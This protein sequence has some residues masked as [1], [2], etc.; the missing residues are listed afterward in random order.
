MPIF[1]V[2][3][4]D[5]ASGCSKCLF[6][7]SKDAK[8]AELNANKRGLFVSKTI[9]LD[10]SRTKMSDSYLSHAAR[11]L[12]DAGE[13]AMALRALEEKSLIPNKGTL[14]DCRFI[15][16][17]LVAAG[18]TDVAWRLLQEAKIAGYSKVMH[19]YESELITISE[20]ELTV[21]QSDDRKNQADR[22][23]TMIAFSSPFSM[24]Y[25]PKDLNAY[26][27]N[28][29]V[30]MKLYEGL[31]EVHERVLSRVFDTYLQHGTLRAILCAQDIALG[32]E[33]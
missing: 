28:V 11:L 17:F 25:P 14:P 29:M 10:S 23:R 33:E 9:L 15:V 19:S 1:A 22:W 6:I 8:S 3:G 30:A 32:L 26:R 24:I 12:C 4:A 18:Q 20:L 21:L 31:S 13:P 27:T 5:S 16:P 2:I 7:G